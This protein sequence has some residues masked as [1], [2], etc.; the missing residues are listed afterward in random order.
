MAIAAL[1]REDEQDDALQAALRL[2]AAE[3]STSSMMTSTTTSTTP[4][5]PQ[6]DDA[7]DHALAVA[8]AASLAEE[9]ASDSDL[10]LALQ[11]QEEE[12]SA[13]SRR[14]AARL[15]ERRTAERRNERV[16][17][18]AHLGEQTPLPQRATSAEEAQDVGSMDEILAA[19]GVHVDDT[20]G[21]GLIGRRE[22]GS[23][24]SKHDPSLD[25]R[26]KAQCLQD[27]FANAGDIRQERVPARVYNELLRKQQ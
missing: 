20:L 8:L 14:E 16:R 24:V 5:P 6:V 26:L 19:E 15:A 25:A 10:A 9:D 2:S 17:V 22:D 1:E 4:P 27:T 11:L 7:E 23:L 12:Q 13:R 3:A 18:V 21:P